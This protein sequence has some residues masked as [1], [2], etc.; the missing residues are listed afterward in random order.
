MHRLRQ[1][2][3]P[4]QKWVKHQCVGSHGAHFHTE[5]SICKNPTCC[6]RRLSQVVTPKRQQA[7]PSHLPTAAQLRPSTSHLQTSAPPRPCGAPVWKAGPGTHIQC[8]TPGG[9]KTCESAEPPH[10]QCRPLHRHGGDSAHRWP[11]KGREGRESNEHLVNVCWV[12]EDSL[13]FF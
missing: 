13:T 10:G 8:R 4:S 9:E 5:K 12:L 11:E 7:P 2:R 1:P 3:G 6:P